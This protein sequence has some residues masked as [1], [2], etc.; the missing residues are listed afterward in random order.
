MTR[1]TVALLA[2]I[3]LSACSTPDPSVEIPMP[4][5]DGRPPA[6][7][8]ADSPT[9]VAGQAGGAIG[10]DAPSSI[11]VDPPICDDDYVIQVA[12]DVE[13]LLPCTTITGRLRIKGTALTEVALPNLVSAEIKLEITDNPQ[14]TS[15]SLPAFATTHI[16]TVTDNPVLTEFALPAYTKGENV[17]ISSNGALTTIDLS[18]MDDLALEFRVST[19]PLLTELLLTALAGGLDT[20]APLVVANNAT[21]EQLELPSLKEAA[22]IDVHDNLQLASLNL[23]ALIVVRGHFEVE[24]NPELVDF[25][26]PALQ[27]SGTDQPHAPLRIADNAA[28]PTLSFPALVET[29]SS[30]EILDNAMLARLQ[31]PALV[32]PEPDISNGDL[33]VEGNAMLQQIELP[34]LTGLGHGDGQGGRSGGEFIVLDNAA[35][36]TIT[37]PLLEAVSVFVVEGNPRLARLDVPQLLGAFSVDIIAND[38]LLSVAYPL[39]T[40]ASNLRINDNAELTDLSLPQLTSVFNAF[41]I[42]NNP[43]LPTCQAQSILDALA[44]RRTPGQVTNND[45]AATCP[46]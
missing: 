6:G 17:V 44:P 3:Q 23:P 2:A 28:L 25:E 13:A 24:R 21:L 8:G 29:G 9:G 30:L 35:L 36:T 10:P 19:N 41:E 7:F 14:L 46:P 20:G 4:T 18:A 27:E 34:A 42:T 22:S 39:L 40:S 26:V 15:V 1:T 16:L 5:D 45:N 32:A 37:V 38:T 33:H 11:Q 43:R 31:L 12:A